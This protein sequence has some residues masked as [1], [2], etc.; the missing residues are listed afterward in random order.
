MTEPEEVTTIRRVIRK[1]IIKRIVMIDGKPVETEEVVE[2]PEDVSEETVKALPA[3]SVVTETITE[4]D[5]TTTHRIVRRVIKKII[6]V[7]GKPVETEEVVEEPDVSEMIQ[8]IKP[9]DTAI[10]EEITEPTVSRVI[11]KRIMVDGKPVEREEVINKPVDIS[12]EMVER[13]P[14][15]LTI[16]E[17]DEVSTTTVRRIIRKRIIKKIVMIDGKPVETEEV[18]EEP[19][20]VSE[21]M[22]E[23]MPGES[24]ITETI[25]EPEEV[26]TIHRIIRR[27]IIKKIIMVD[28]KPVETE[29]VVEEPEEVTGEMIEAKPG[30]SVITETITEPDEV[31]TTTVRR[32]IRRRVIK[33]IV[34]IDGKPVETEEVIEEPEEVSEEMVEGAPEESFITETITEPEDVITTHRIIRRRVIKKII[35]VDGKPVETEEVVEE[36]EEVTEE[37]LQTLPKDSVITETI[38]EPEEVTTTHR[39]IR[40]RVIKKIIMVDGKPV[41]TE[42]VVEEPEEI[43]KEMID[44]V[45]DKSVITETMMEPEGITTIQKIIRR[46]KKIIMVDGKPV[47]TEEVMEEPEEVSKMQTLPK[48]SVVTETTTEPEEV[49][50][51]HRIIRRRVIKK[52]I[53]VDGKPV[54]TEEV[55]EEPEEVTGEMAEAKPGE[56]VITETITEPDEVTTTTVHR[57]I[58]RRI[59][60]KIVMIDGKPVETEEV[61]EEP[62]EVSEEELQ[63]LPKDSVITETITEP[64]EV[65]TTHRIIRRRIIKKIIMVDGKP[66]ETEEVVEE[67][68]E[69]TDGEPVPII[70]GGTRVVKKNVKIKRIV[71]IVDG[72]EVVEEERSETPEEVLEY[73][74]GTGSDQPLTL[75]ISQDIESI[76]SDA[77]QS[78]E[79]PVQQARVIRQLRIVDGQPV[80][81]EEI[82][83][84]AENIPS[85]TSVLETRNIQV[86]AV[87]R[88]MKVIRRVQIINGERVVTEEVVEEPE[89]E[90][91]MPEDGSG[92][93]VT[94]M[95]EGTP[96]PIPQ[97]EISEAPSPSSVIPLQWEEK[98]YPS[99]IPKSEPEE[100]ITGEAYKITEVM[101]KKPP[102]EERP[103]DP[104]PAPVSSFPAPAPVSDA[105]PKDAAE[106]WSGTLY[107]KASVDDSSK[108]PIPDTAGQAPAFPEQPA[109]HESEEDFEPYPQPGDSQ[110]E[111]PWEEIAHDLI[112]VTREI[113]LTTDS[114]S[115]EVKDSE[116]QKTKAFPSPGDLAVRPEDLKPVSKERR[117]SVGESFP[118]F[119]RRDSGVAE[120]CK[121]FESPT[122]SYDTPVYQR[123]KPVVTREKIQDTTKPYKSVEIP[124]WP[125]SKEKDSSVKPF[126]RPVGDVPLPSYKDSTV[127]RDPINR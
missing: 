103:Q 127:P 84:G 38:T 115:R 27:R 71:R 20:E 123:P 43:S 2:E 4:P 14:G 63:A 74:E 117:S 113:S 114:D 80:V 31:T 93:T 57:I 75:P 77:A 76:L 7:D 9:T 90:F 18:I 48:D 40:R 30:E 87:R 125:P 108:E 12:G 105:K 72:K 116:D 94:D 79:T 29:E 34:M 39:I 96:F 19:E 42:E 1:R 81:S 35:M 17:P 100:K 10:T 50:T 69:S 21:E 122:K 101:S 3:D 89:T 70:S 49:T 110:G 111:E 58:R 82:L 109:H 106:I 26:T 86:H 66:V 112:G 56:S 45:Q 68:E 11:H 88:R 25:K 102:T 62:E 54:E 73:P 120:L 64:E 107:T 55:V 5:V 6:M 47:E 51:T 60:K 121:I 16:T 61:V 24:V 8:S 59:I 15:D 83:E 119:K 65:I 28:G 91:G 124:A 36:P 95:T 85:D 67:P 44:G 23:G 22:V 46:V 53:M 92:V 118:S 33:K 52:I 98:T 99:G 32:I 126:P 78:P 13:T 41:E 104:F 37:E 97:T